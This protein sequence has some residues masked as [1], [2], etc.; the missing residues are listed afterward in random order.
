[1]Y[2]K[3]LAIYESYPIDKLVREVTFKE[4]VNF[5]VD[6][7]N[8]KGQRGNGV[9]KTTT[10]KLIDIC[11]GS[12]EKKYIYT[13]AELDVENVELKDYIN[14]S[15]VF[16]ELTVCESLTDRDAVC[17]VL[18]VDLYS[19]GRRYINDQQHPLKEYQGQ[20]ARIFF[21]NRNDKPSFRELIGMFVR[22]DQKSDND[23]FLHYLSDFTANIEYENVYN[24][25]FRL[26]DEAV[27][28]AVRALKERAK[29][30][31]SDRKKLLKINGISSINIVD[32]KVVEIDKV[33]DGVKKKLDV[34]IDAESMKA[35]EESISE[36]KN[37]YL[38]ITNQIDKYEFRS[39]RVQ[40]IISSSKRDSLK[41]VDRSVLKNLYDETK[42]YFKELNKTFD[43]LI[44]FNEQI[45]INK[46]A[47]FDNQ[48]EEINKRLSLLEQQREGLFEHYKD[49]VVL[50]KDN[51]IAQY[52]Q[53]QSELEETLK[54]KG[55]LEN[56]L[57]NYKRLTKSHELAEEEL[58]KM[59]ADGVD[60]AAN[61]SIYNDYFTSYTQLI[62]HE[63][64]LLYL[65]DKDFP[66]GISNVKSGFSTGTK[67][68]VIAAFDLAYQSYAQ[69][70][71]IQS[72]RFI[73]HDVIETMDEVG[74]SNTVKIAN[75]IK[76]QYIA[77]VLNDKL[78]GVENVT[79]VDKRLLLSD[80]N[81]LFGV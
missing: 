17:D 33:I 1:M 77:A 9:G 36:A 69:K 30:L 38:E 64:Y 35:N 61:I 60:P 63:S 19:N 73:V 74:L 8:K 45:I 13:D 23:R 22:L 54:E 47:Y 57:E 41:K 6:T 27:S 34:L 65:T 40:E 31:M 20:L 11:L 16:A 53:L 79:E 10:L 67:K 3:R 5:I 58:G 25:L 66:I 46:I 51:N 62:N 43:Q 18:R 50:I 26:S 21:N 70:Q 28:E 71:G 24:Y 32:Q 81:K 76:C 75:K 7:K 4:G 39:Q 68:S 2:I 72:P 59:T 44:Q 14:N 49:V 15:K 48:L 52:A 42:G 80:D 37:K 55:S 56:I 29:L 78:H 12:Q